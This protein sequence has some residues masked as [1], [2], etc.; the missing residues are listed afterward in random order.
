[1]ARFGWKSFIGGVVVGALGLE[2]LRQKEAD[3]VLVGVT[4][5]VL[6]AKDWVM[7]RVEKIQARASDVYDDAKGKTEG[8]LQRTAAGAEAEPARGEDE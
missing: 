1:M 5:G 8:Y 6:V 3:K 2:L 4:E 7:E